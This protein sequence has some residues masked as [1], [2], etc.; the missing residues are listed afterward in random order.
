MKFQTT[1]M[2]KTL[3]FAAIISIGLCSCGKSTDNSNTTETAPTEMTKSIYDYKVT[4][5]TGD[6]IDFADFK[7]KKLMIV[8]TASEC[9]YTYQY[10][11]LEALYKKYQDKLTVVGFPANDFGLQEPGTNEEIADFCKEN[12]GVTFPMAE[13]IS[14][15]GDDMAPIYQWLTQK[16]QNGFENSSIEWNFQKYLIDENG[17]L[18]GIYESKTEPN[19]S[20]IISAIEQ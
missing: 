13:K 2:K 9:G 15:K 11:G 17:K 20:E 19:S 18:I 1:S 3:L 16:D 12:Y 7:G 4:S 10:E 6:T 8:N 14:V 5:L